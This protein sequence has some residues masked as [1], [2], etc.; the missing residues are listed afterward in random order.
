MDNTILLILLY[1]SI[2]TIV[3]QCLC[4][5]LPEICNVRIGIFL[6]KEEKKKVSPSVVF[7]ERVSSRGCTKEIGG[8]SGTYWPL[9]P[10]QLPSASS[11][12]G[13][14]K[15]DAGWKG[16]RKAVQSF[17]TEIWQSLKLDN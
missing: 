2:V 8:F 14:A 4:I 11:L 9:N 17:G 7:P 13:G 15:E 16:R 10:L 1:L 6:R 3:D 5:F 12:V